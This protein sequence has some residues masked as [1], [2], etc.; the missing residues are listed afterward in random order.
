M[1][2][3][4]T[5]SFLSG[6][7]L[8]IVVAPVTGT[9]GAHQAASVW[10]VWWDSLLLFM[11]VLSLVWLWPNWGLLS[12]FKYWPFVWGRLFAG[13]TWFVESVSY[14]PSYDG[15]VWYGLGIVLAGGHYA[16][17]VI[18]IWHEKQEE[19]QQ[20]HCAGSHFTMIWPW[21]ASVNVCVLVWTDCGF[22]H[23]WC[24][25]LPPPW[26]HQL[27]RWVHTVGTVVRMRFYL[28][29][30]VMGQEKI[31]SCHDGLNKAN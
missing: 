5:A 24:P 18:A 12:S 4:A 23:D 13:F 7:W 21:C 16:M 10:P 6:A 17:S 11:C 8:H 30:I 1:H 31:R 2:W 3:M 29:V 15:H 28:R 26:W 19:T 22:E 27:V 25:F 14:L 9:L 20:K